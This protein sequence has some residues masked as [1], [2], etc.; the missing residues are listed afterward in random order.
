M[1]WY[2]WHLGDYF[3]DYEGQGCDK[4]D[5]ASYSGKTWPVDA[6]PSTL[7]KRISIVDLFIY[8]RDHG[9]FLGLWGI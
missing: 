8:G 7:Q 6:D 2:V 4:I 3:H 9:Y 1:M 5:A